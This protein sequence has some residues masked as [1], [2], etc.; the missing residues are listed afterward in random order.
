MKNLYEIL[1]EN[2]KGD[3][4]LEQQADAIA[5]MLEVLFKRPCRNYSSKVTEKEL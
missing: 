1:V 5:D 3:P 4:F 2:S